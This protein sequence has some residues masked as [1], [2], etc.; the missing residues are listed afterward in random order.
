MSLL[1]KEKFIT[2]ILITDYGG[3][4]TRCAAGLGLTR[5]YLHTYVQNSAARAGTK[6][7]TAVYKHCLRVERKPEIYLFP[8][9]N[10]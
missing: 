2:D 4:I 10:D 6:L 8:T 1:N 9:Q 7:I 5:V 3:N